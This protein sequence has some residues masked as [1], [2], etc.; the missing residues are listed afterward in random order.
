MP[1]KQAF[2]QLNLT[3]QNQLIISTQ[4]WKYE[5]LIVVSVVYVDHNVELRWTKPTEYHC[6]Q[7]LTYMG[8]IQKEMFTL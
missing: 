5:V 6:R 8:K 2:K 3:L 1:R 4:I 7:Q